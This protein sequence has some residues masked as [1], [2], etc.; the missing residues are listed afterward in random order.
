MS[1]TA[2]NSPTARAK[3]SATPDRI[4]GATVG[5]TMRRK[6]AAGDAPSEAA[7][8]S[9]SRSSSCRTGCTVRT[10]NGSVTNRSQQHAPARVRDADAR[11]SLR[12]VEREERQPGDDRRER[13]PEVDDRVD[14]AL[15]PERVADQDPR[16][17]RPEHGVDGGDDERR[18]ERELQGC[19]G[20]W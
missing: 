15:P 17:Q 4:A 13:E 10:T 6:I 9:T 19:D 2:P 8:S 18:A 5:R 7:A 1:T 14:R 16:D 12:P 3:A 20:L 11:G